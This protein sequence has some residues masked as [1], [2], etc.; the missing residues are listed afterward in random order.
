[1]FNFTDILTGQSEASSSLLLSVIL[2]WSVFWKGLALWHSAR[3]KQKY[4][5][6]ALLV[7][8]TI[9]F[10]EI[11]FLVFFKKDKNKVNKSREKKS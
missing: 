7:V 4:W 3:N 1:V 10:L 5:F 2:L 8:N 6:V 9:G 11:L